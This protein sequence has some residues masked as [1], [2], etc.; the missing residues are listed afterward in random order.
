MAL[1]ADR[2]L[3]LD[4]LA[5]HLIRNVNGSTIISYHPTMALPTTTAEFFHQRIRFAG[6]CWWLFCV[7]DVKSLLGQSVYWQS[8]FQKSPDA[9]FVLLTFIWHAVYAWDEALE[10]LYKH[11]CTLVRDTHICIS[12][13]LLTS[14]TQESRVITTADMPLTKE[15]HVIRAHHLHYTSL[16]EDFRKHVFFVRDTH[17]PALDSLSKIEQDFSDSLLKRECANLLSEIERLQQDLTM[18]ERRLK[19]VMGLVGTI[20]V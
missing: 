8:I 7:I 15:L 10:D 14:M 20:I 3:H 13:F 18:Q 2:L 11:I 17:N 16:L 12:L 5:V 4:L 9:T 6:M 1:T 19:N